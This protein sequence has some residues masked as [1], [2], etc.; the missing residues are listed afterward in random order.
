MTRSASPARYEFDV[1]IRLMPPSMAA[2]MSRIDSSSDVGLRMLSVPSASA[3]TNTPLRPSRRVC[4]SAP[5]SPRR[6]GTI[7]PVM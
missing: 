1:S 7:A 4:I 2:W 6:R 5:C 3:D